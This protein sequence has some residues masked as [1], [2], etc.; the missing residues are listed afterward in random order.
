MLENYDFIGVQNCSVSYQIVTILTD[1]EIATTVLYNTKF[2]SI[3]Q[4]FFINLCGKIVLVKI[5]NLENIS[6]CCVAL[7]YLPSVIIVVN[8]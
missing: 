6:G 1:Y 5:N 4:Q 2:N 8:F 3:L 7:F